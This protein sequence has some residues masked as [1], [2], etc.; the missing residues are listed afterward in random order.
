MAT[1]SDKLTVRANGETIRGVKDM[2]RNMDGSCADA[3]RKLLRKGLE[4]YGF[5]D[6]NGET[7]LKFV[8]IELSRVFL[9]SAAALVFVGLA[10]GPLLWSW[11]TLFIVLGLAMTAIGMR[12]PRLTYTFRRLFK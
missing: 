9:Y 10:T 6:G 4:Y 5:V 8:A 12:E 2:A 1:N 3:H 11:A 7:R